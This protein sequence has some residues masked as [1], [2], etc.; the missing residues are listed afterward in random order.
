MSALVVPSMAHPRVYESLSRSLDP[1]LSCETHSLS[2][3]CVSTKHLAAPSVFSLCACVALVAAAD[4]V[5]NFLISRHGVQADKEL[6]ENRLMPGLAGAM[7]ENPSAVFDIVEL[8]TILV[9]PQLKKAADSGDDMDIQQLFGQ[10]LKMILSD[11]YGSENREPPQ[12]D[13]E[14]MALIL[15]TYG[16]VDVP[17]QVID[18]MLASAGVLRGGETEG[19]LD[20][21][22]LV[23]AATSDL[24]RYNNEWSD[25]FTTHYDDVFYGTSLDKR[26]SEIRKSVVENL[27]EDEKED[28]NSIRKLFS[29]ASIDY[30]AENYTSKAFVTLLWLLLV[31]LFFVYFLQLQDSIA[32]RISCDRFRN[33]FSCRVANAVVTWLVVF[34][35]LR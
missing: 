13:H 28:E 16:E 17:P 27:K 15:E 7:G 10:V 31:M 1:S 35:Q 6:V 25:K 19:V 23:K 8:V 33:E 11:V 34:V 3:V 21:D 18:E 5:I 14:T 30:V 4:D 24:S 12:L 29:L 20:V 22:T 32:G 9:I 26:S 2:S